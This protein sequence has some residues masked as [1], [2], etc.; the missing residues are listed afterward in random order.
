MLLIHGMADP[1]LSA[2]EMLDYCARLAAHNGGIEATQCFA[3]AYVVPG[4]SRC[5]GY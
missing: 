2:N 3:G 5:S 4:M 1:I